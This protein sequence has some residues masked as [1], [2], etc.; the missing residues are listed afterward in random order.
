MSKGARTRKD[1]I[2]QAFLIAA[3]NG[4]EGVTLGSLAAMT[5]LSKS[6]LFAHFKSKEA[7]QLDVLEE[8][9]QRFTAFVV[10]PALQVPRG[11]QRMRALVD[12]KIDWI[13]H[14][15][16]KGG[17]VFMALAYE[18]D[19]RPGAVRDRLTEA[20]RAW[21]DTIHRIAAAAV[22]QGDF[23][24]DLDTALFV[25]EFLGIEMAFQHSLKLLA[26][27]HAERQARAA[28]DGLIVRSRSVP[29]TS[30]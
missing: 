8:I 9:V 28:F 19:D 10:A 4:L 24:A 3:D 11:E 22:E 20:H 16:P 25:Y 21:A 23:R 26:H 1:I 7:L 30:L 18:Y 15:H 14:N 6:G 29:P 12:R 17:C 27:P 13:I 2:D 5:G